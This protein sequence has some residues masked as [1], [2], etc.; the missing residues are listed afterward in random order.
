MIEIYYYSG[1]GYTLKAAKILTSTL[2]E[3]VK[4]I[5]IIGAM[6]TGQ[7][8]TKATKIGLL[9]P[10]HAFGMPKAFMQFLDVFKCPNASYIFSL[11]TR[12]G[13]PTNMH[14]HINKYLS[15]QGKSLS[16]F[17]Y[18]TTDNT[19]D[20]VMKIH[21]DDD[22]IL[23]KKDFE[24]DIQDFAEVIN[25]NSIRINQG[26]RDYFSEY[27][28]FPAIRL[29]SSVT[30]YFNLEKDYYVDEKCNGCGQCEAMCLSNKIIMED[31]NPNWQET[32]PCQFCFA[33]LQ[34]CPSNAVQV[35]KTKSCNLGRIH[36]SEVT[37]GDIS[38]QKTL[39]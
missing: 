38:A 12:G 16:A 25:D 26:Y 19:F 2:N 18:A 29:L 10:M 5:P 7:T 8:L 14:K 15:K 24:K 1:T 9:M 6:N 31:S 32:I 23:A 17:N 22:V 33:C 28:L 39:G 13:A 11:V 21:T 35:K 36:H 3:E 30:K 20:T 4:L 37:C 27:V 34:L